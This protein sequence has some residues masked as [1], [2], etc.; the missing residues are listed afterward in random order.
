[1]VGRSPRPTGD[2]PPKLLRAWTTERRI[3]QP[4]TESAAVLIDAE[5]DTV[6][7]VL[8]STWTAEIEGWPPWI[9]TGRVPC[10][11][12]GGIGEMEYGVFRRDDGSPGGTVSVVVQYNEGKSVV[13]RDISPSNIR[14][15][16]RLSAVEG[17]TRLEMTREWPGATLVA[18]NDDVVTRHLEY[19][20]QLLDAYKTHIESLPRGTVEPA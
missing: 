5:P 17:K 19:P 16:Y 7:K 12:V 2:I 11:P 10:A 14:A 15:S 1:M 13:T 3:E 9:C 20:R 18:N 4:V 8:T 6:W